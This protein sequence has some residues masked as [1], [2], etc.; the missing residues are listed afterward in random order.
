MTGKY[1]KLSSAFILLLMFSTIST[2]GQQAEAAATGRPEA[3]NLGKTL[4]ISLISEPGN[5]PE[6]FTVMTADGGFMFNSVYTTTSN[7]SNISFQGQVTLLG[8]DTALVDYSLSFEKFTK[9]GE[10]SQKVDLHGS[11]LVGMNSEV[12]IAKSKD[13][14]F[15]LKVSVQK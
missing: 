3:P 10:V 13:R 5:N 14:A 8:N 4:T 6:G 7:R 2:A 11:V 1:A 9:E 12:Y 15:K